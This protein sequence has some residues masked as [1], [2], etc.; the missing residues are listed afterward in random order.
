MSTPDGAT[1][2]R[3]WTKA[4]LR[5]RQDIEIANGGLGLCNKTNINNNDEN[6]NIGNPS[7]SGGKDKERVMKV[8]SESHTKDQK[9]MFTQHIEL[10]ITISCMC[11]S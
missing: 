5:E 6:V 9:K 11:R 8:L 3:R 2:L 7:S 1:P 10:M 4:Y